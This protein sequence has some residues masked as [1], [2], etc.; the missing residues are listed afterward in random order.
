MMPFDLDPA[1]SAALS[2]AVKA[3]V[4]LAAAALV[5]AV[6]YRRLSAAMRHLVWTL[7][8]AGLLLLPIL[9]LALPEW[10]VVVIR[11]AAPERRGRRANDGARRRIQQPRPSRR[12][13]SRH[14]PSPRP[15]SGRPP[16]SPFG[17]LP[18]GRTRLRGRV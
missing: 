7:A 11:T 9:S 14:A 17:A 6:L 12:R 3:S 10:A 5:Q 15:M 8:V 13:L 4:L 16:G 18:P 2:I 1:T